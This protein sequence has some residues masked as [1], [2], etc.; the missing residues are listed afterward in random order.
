MTSPSAPAASGSV[1]LHL[2]LGSFHRAH[3]AVYLQALRATGD[4]EWSLAGTNLRPDMADVLAALQAQGGAYTLE[5]VSP[6]GEYRYERIESIREV[7]PYARGQAAMVARGADPATRIVSFTVTEAGYYLDNDHRLDLGFADLAADIERVRRGEAGETVYG[8]VTAILR[9]RMAANAGSVTL[10][11]CDNLRHNGERF[12]AGL[13]EFIDRIGDAPLLAWTPANT[14][15]PNAMVDRITPR[16]PAELRERVRNAT[17]WDDAAPVTGESFIQWVIED[18]FIAGRP[19]WEKVGVEL[20]ASV[21]P[22]EEAKIRILN[23]SHS[24]IAWAGTLLGLQFIHEGTLTPSIRQMAF[25]YVTDD[26]IPCL[27]NPSAPSPVDLPRYRD[28]VLERFSNPAIRD[29]NQRVAADG[30]SKI[31]GFIAPT[32][33]ERLAA[34]ATIDSVAMLPA[35]FLAF[36]QRWHRG[37]LPYAYQDQGMDAAVAHAICD[38]ADPVAALCADAGLW[39]ELAGDGRLVSA[40]RR[41]ADRVAM[42]EARQGR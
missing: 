10:L 9:A 20:V 23:A 27:S 26:V 16:P 36:L 32:V 13:L 2:G 18:D 21:Q 24:C 4:L 40:M 15:C 41:A 1:V 22:Y 33:R 6:A 25:D 39:G 28:V 38:A 17:G 11:N 8:A 42:F 19:A 29:T 7:I 12:R 35:L 34:G 14:T 31:P 30:F 5:T 37:E 3:Q